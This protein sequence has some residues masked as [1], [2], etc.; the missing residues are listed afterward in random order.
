MTFSC[1]YSHH[2]DDIFVINF[3]FLEKNNP[4]RELFRNLDQLM[5]VVVF[6]MYIHVEDKNRKL[7]LN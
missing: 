2:V 5:A 3:E 6:C 4:E 7:S 1:D